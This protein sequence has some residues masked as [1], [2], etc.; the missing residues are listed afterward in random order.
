MIDV[1]LVYSVSFTN[2][3]L[4]FVNLLT[5]DLTEEIY[6]ISIIKGIKE[7]DNCI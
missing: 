4:Y 5:Y 1:N 3:P 6:V 7:E 2:N